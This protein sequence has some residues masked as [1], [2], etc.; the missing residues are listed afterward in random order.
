[1]N[2]YIRKSGCKP[3]TSKTYFYI[4][5]IYLPV[6]MVRNIKYEV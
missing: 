5:F 2:K 6:K 1:M 3:V 4:G